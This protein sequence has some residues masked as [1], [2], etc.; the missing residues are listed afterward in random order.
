MSH[1]KQPGCKLTPWRGRLCYQ[2]W[3]E[4]RGWIF[5]TQR[6]VFVK[7]GVIKQERAA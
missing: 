6:K 4:S 7:R 5:D 1:C 2:H 3:R